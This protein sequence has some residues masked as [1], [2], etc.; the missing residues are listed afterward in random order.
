MMSLVG[1]R[2]ARCLTCNRKFYARYTMNEQGKYI[3]KGAGKRAV[4]SANAS[5]AA[6]GE[7]HDN[8][9]DTAA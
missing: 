3:L 7:Q 6:D 8:S 5:A 2:P 4:I 9:L 1:L